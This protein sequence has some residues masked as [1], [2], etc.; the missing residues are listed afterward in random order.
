MASR[1]ET[2][3]VP[4]PDSLIRDETEKIQEKEKAKETRIDDILQELTT[5]RETGFYNYVNKIQPLHILIYITIILVVILLSDYI[6][7]SLKHVVGFLL[8]ITYVY[9][10]NEGKQATSIDRLKTTEIHMEQII[11]RPSFFHYDA[12]F[13]EFA[14]NM[15]SYREYNTTAYENMI[16]AMDNFLE[17][18]I[19]IENPVLINCAETY[20]VAVDMK[21]TA[22][23][24]LHSLS[25]S[26]PHDDQLVIKTKLENAIKT[27]QLYLQR[28][29]DEMVETCNSRTDTNGWDRKTKR[30][31][32]HALPGNDKLKLPNYHLF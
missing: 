32:K 26:I 9:Y 7:W 4:V 13:I 6:P 29:L 21:T 5:L 14:Y 20:Q 27:L 8:G 10:L 3:I 12:N 24:E 31:D 15:L 16:K 28:H 22:L 19:D 17:I 11:P 2:H 1:D 30:I 25:H 18:Q 23:N